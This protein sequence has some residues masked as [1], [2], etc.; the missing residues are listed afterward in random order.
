LGREEARREA[1]HSGLARAH[2][3][4]PEVVSGVHRVPNLEERDDERAVLW[5]RSFG[6]ELQLSQS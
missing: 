5:D 6:A 4:C 3:L 2:L 1:R